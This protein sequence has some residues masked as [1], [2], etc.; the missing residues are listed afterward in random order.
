MAEEK[1]KRG[2]RTYL[3]D[4]QQ[5]AGGD[6]VYTGALHPFAGSAGER[7][8]AVAALWLLAAGMAAAAVAAGCVP[9]AGMQ[10]CAYVLLPCA[11]SVVGAGSVVWL[12]CRLT[13]G[14][15]P[16]RDYVYRATVK[17]MKPRGALTMAFSAASLLGDG[18]FLALHGAG[19]RLWG[20]AAF[21][22]CQAA[23]AG[24]CAG[25]LRLAGRLRWDPGARE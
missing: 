6:Y 4:F 12:M 24:C 15:D 11:G 19:D 9:A 10:D 5:T 3:N 23:V 8:R 7:K 17:Q 20:T 22:L 16:L 14:G 18:V 2:R 25:W 1:R 13:A 21:W